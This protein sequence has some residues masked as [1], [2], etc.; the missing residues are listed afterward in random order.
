MREGVAKTDVVGFACGLAG[1]ALWWPLL[2]RP[3]CFFVLAGHDATL[4]ASRGWYA[5]FALVTLA[6]ALVVSRPG[7]RLRRLAGPRVSPAARVGVA[8][9]FAGQLAL[10]LAGLSGAPTGAA[11]ALVAAADVVLFAGVFVFLTCAWATW[12]SRMP[13][14][15]R[16]AACTAS[17]AASFFV[18]TIAGLAAGLDAACMAVTPLASL[19][20]AAVALRR[21]VPAAPR[22]DGSPAPGAVPAR[23]L[24][25]MTSMLALFLVI[26]A[27]TRSMAFGQLSGAL[28]SPVPSLQ[29]AL[30]IALAGVVLAYGVFHASLGRL[31]QFVW[32]L[33]TL[34]LFAG[35][36]LMADAATGVRAAGEQIMVVG[37][38]VLGLLFWL[39]LAD[40]AQAAG[41]SPVRAV[42]VP[43]IEVDAVSSLLGYV[44]VPGALSLAGM[45]SAGDLTTTLA[46]TVTF[47]LVMVSVVFFG[48]TL[49]TQARSPESASEPSASAPACGPAPDAPGLLPAAL[50]QAGLTEREA[51]VARLLAEGNSQKKVAEVLGVSMGTV[52]SHVKAVYRKLGV[53]SKQEL[54]DLARS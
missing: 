30:T 49:G 5:L 31:S 45:D 51:E 48:R 17:F 44:V 15:W 16:L 21:G 29:D 20:C 35:L 6:L 1:L 41:A 10:K 24:H 38:T 28:L 26:A 27:V 39:V 54:I 19:A 7:A 4:A 47:A 12:C 37:R 42:A 36:F 50:A 53:H 33:A 52:Q 2:R 8:A 14:R 9:L 3:A 32:P 46:S 11:G 43:F 34:V 40:D 22:S 25:G 13:F 18:R 23:P